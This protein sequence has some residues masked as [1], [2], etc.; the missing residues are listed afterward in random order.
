MAVEKKD[1]VVML[2]QQTTNEI[3][4]P[5]PIVEKQ[6]Y[7]GAHEVCPRDTSLVIAELYLQLLEN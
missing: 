7:S 1:E 3:L 4:K 6:D 5:V 2:E